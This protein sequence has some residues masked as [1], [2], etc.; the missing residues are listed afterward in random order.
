[1]SKTIKHTIDVREGVILVRMQTNC[2]L[3]SLGLSSYSGLS[4]A[5]DCVKHFNMRLARG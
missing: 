1:M 5:L 3:V 2:V 4:D